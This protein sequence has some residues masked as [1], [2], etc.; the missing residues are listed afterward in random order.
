MRSAKRR[1]WYDEIYDTYVSMHLRGDEAN[2]VEWT[3]FGRNSIDI[4]F[5]D[6]SVFRYNYFRNSI[7]RLDIAINDIKAMA[8]QMREMFPHKISKALLDAGCSQKELA[9][10]IGATECTV[11][12][13]CSGKRLPNLIT[14]SIMA[15]FLNCDLYELIPYYDP[16]DNRIK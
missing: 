8:E 7:T 11:S 4:T 12:H 2:I 9:H 5:R 13:Y 6:G 1:D 10:G 3:P 14:I 15:K 16:K